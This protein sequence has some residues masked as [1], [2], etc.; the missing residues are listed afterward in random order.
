MILAG[1]LLFGLLIFG[2]MSVLGG[3]FSSDDGGGSDASSFTV[4]REA[5]PETG[6]SLDYQTNLA[7][8]Q[9]ASVRNRN[10][11]GS[12]Y[13]DVPSEELVLTDH[14]GPR[15][16]YLGDAGGNPEPAFPIVAG[17]QFRAGCEFSHFSYDDPLLFPDRPGASHLHMHFGNTD[18]N[19]FSTFDSLL[20]SG[21]STC[22]GQELNRTGYW[23]PAMFDS[24]GNV[25]VPER[26]V[27]YYKGEGRARGEAQAYPDGA[28]LIATENINTLPIEQGGAGGKLSYVCSNNFSVPSDLASQTMPVCDGS[29]FKDL[30]GVDDNPRVVLEMNVKFNQCWNGQDPANWNNFIAS[31]GGWYLSNCPESHPNILPNLEYFVNYKVDV[32]E[33]T[34]GWYLSS[35][36]DPTDFGAAKATP[37][38][39]IHGD[40]WG[41]WNKEVA[42]QWI[43]NCV[44]FISDVASGCGFGYLTDGGPDNTAP[45]DGPALKMR[46][47]YEGPYKI[48]AETILRELCPDQSRQYNQ[49][50]D[51]AFCVPGVGV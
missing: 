43:P 24:Q 3:L 40:W 23:V 46:P 27:V 6:S 48:P 51:A 33:T 15:S 41:G 21:S 9:A 49:P 35:D 4:G 12:P 42:D 17:G 20:N 30:Y 32:G 25:R 5:D 38:S 11:D 13:R 39:T 45:F 19:A 50:E 18:V 7:M 44:N 1:L 2:V 14:Y 8:I 16:E 29:L 28:A 37:G 26:V 34:E 47:Q 36:I 10:H 31:P 22:N